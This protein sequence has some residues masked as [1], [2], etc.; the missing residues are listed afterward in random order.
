VLGDF[1]DVAP[2]L[3]VARLQPGTVQA[4]ALLDGSLDLLVVA[5]A[6]VSAACVCS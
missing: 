1:V 2:E 5:E 4:V 6:L 3:G